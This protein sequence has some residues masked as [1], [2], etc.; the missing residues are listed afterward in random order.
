MA[1]TCLPEEQLALAVAA[2]WCCITDWPFEMIKLYN[3]QQAAGL[4]AMTVQEI[5]TAARCNIA[6]N[7]SI[8]RGIEQ[9]LECQLAGG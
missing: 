3:L 1:A 7:G 5:E 2:G 4:G 6:C 8:P 9:W